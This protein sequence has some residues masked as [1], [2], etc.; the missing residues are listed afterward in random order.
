MADQDANVSVV[1]GERFVTPVLPLRDV[2]V[3]PHMVIPLFVGRDKSIKA[4]DEA[5]GNDKQILLVSQ[6]SAEIDD[7]AVAD[8]HP[9]GTLATVLQLLKLPDGTVKV[10]VEGERRALVHDYVATDPFFAGELRD[11]PVA[12]AS[13]SDPTNRAAALAFID[14][15]G[16]EIV[17]E[18]APEDTASEDDPPASGEM[19]IY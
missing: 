10:L 18:T 9:I 8:I 17:E 15:Y 7:P 14:R 1:D 13:P 19:R 12:E 11:F 16:G 4:L 6:R 2:V 5:L 3:F